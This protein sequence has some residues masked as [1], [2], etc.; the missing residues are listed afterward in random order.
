MLYLLMFKLFPF[1]MTYTIIYELYC[2]SLPF[3]MF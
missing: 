2:D 3:S 1:A